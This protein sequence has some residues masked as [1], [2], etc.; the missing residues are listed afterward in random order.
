MSTNEPPIDSSLPETAGDVLLNDSWA[1]TGD[2]A[3]SPRAARSRRQT[4]A[5]SVDLRISVAHRDRLGRQETHVAL[6]PGYS[7]RGTSTAPWF[8]GAP[9][10]AHPDDGSSDDRRETIRLSEVFPASI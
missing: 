3:A 7:S 8:V 9:R 5:H 2:H 6:R 10:V 4:L 1:A